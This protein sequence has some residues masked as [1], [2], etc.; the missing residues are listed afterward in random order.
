MTGPLPAGVASHEEAWKQLLK[1]PW[2]RGR[3]NETY[4]TLPDAVAEE[5]ALSASSPC[6]TRTRVAPS[7]MS[8]RRPSSTATA[9]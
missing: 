2:I 9:G 4:V 7:A 8:Q 6:T 1:T 5:L 3:A